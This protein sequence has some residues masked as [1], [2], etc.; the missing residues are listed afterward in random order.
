LHCC[1][2]EDYELYLL[3]FVF[4][5]HARHAP[6]LG[7]LDPYCDLGFREDAMFHG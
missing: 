2:V 1:F 3:F 7:D 4:P 5:P 6:G